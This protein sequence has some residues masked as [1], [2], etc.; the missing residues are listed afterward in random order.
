MP[1]EATRLLLVYLIRVQSVKPTKIDDAQFM[2][3]EILGHCVHSDKEQK[4]IVVLA[5]LQLSHHH[6]DQI[7]IYLGRTPVAL[8][9]TKESLIH[10]WLA[11]HGRTSRIQPFYPNTTGKFS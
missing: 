6:F 7:G 9:L 2:S 4:N 1:L 8:E 5:M 11:L 10:V 3:N